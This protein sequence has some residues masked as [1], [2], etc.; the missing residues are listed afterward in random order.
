MRIIGGIH[1]TRSILAPAGRDTTRPITDRVKENLFNRLMA[2]GLPSDDEDTHV[3]D[4]F[5][6]TGSLGLEALSRGAD[7]C[8]FVENDPDAVRL[9]EGNLARLDLTDYATVLPVDALSERW[10]QM[11]PPK[12][13]ELVFC[14]PPYACTRDKEPMRQIQTLIEMLA[15]YVEPGGLLALRTQSSP[16]LCEP[17]GWPQLQTYTDGS[18]QLC[19]YT[20]C[21][22]GGQPQ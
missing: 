5:A 12:P 18:M 17:D 2:M 21:F 11:L 9:I 13:A 8:T 20:R 15:A 6:G 14:D 7:H 1:R 4:L 3:L 16:S 19:L 22:S 10:L